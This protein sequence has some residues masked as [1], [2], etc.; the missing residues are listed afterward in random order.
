MANR[1]RFL[2]SAAAAGAVG[3]T[4]TAGCIGDIT[5]G[6]S[7]G[8]EEVRMVLN[9]AEGSVDMQEQYQPLFDYLEEETDA[10]IEATEA[11]SYTA[12]VEAIRN[13]QAEL[14]DISPSGVIAA[15]DQMDIV[16]IR[17][18]YGAERY[19]SLITT[20]PDSGIE[21]LSDIED[22]VIGLSG[23]LSVSGSLFPLYMLSQAGLD[24]GSAPDGNPENFE[25][26][27]SDHDTA[28]NTMME[29]DDVH[30]AGTGAFVSAPYVPE[31]QFSDQFMEVSAE[32]DGVGE[33]DDELVLL[34]ESDPIPRAPIVSRSNWDSSLKEDIETALLEVEE[35]DIVDPD[36]EEP[37][38]FTGLV[39]GSVDDYE[40]IE[41]VM[42]ELG[43]EFADIADA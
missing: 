5:G 3:I 12:T 10:T 20:T 22:Q 24:T 42:D 13:D 6:G 43:L 21:E 39:E 8:D 18:A 15:P 41:N 35:D 1:R 28:L 37:L 7:S 17:V 9:P 14:A 38:W 33:E 30:A 31:D 23:R 26:E 2:K 25:T 19:F 34:A 29:R 4:G 36:A 16:G 32:A 40:P 27:H 11:D